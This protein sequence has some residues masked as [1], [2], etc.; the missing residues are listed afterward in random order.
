MQRDLRESK[1]GRYSDD[2]LAA[3]CTHL[4]GSYWKVWPT[5][6]HV[7]MLRHAAGRDADLWGITFRS[8]PT[9]E[10]ALAA[11]DRPTRICMLP[12]VDQ[13]RVESYGFGTLTLVERRGAVEVYETSTASP[14]G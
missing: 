10:Q 9:R 1:V 13:R 3:D 5:V 2:V 12:G 11:S 4:A 14:R 6:L 7:K 8:T